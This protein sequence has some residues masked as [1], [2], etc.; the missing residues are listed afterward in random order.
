MCQIESLMVASWVDYVRLTWGVVASSNN[1][2]ED[3]DDLAMRVNL[4]AIEAARSAAYEEPGQ[5]QRSLVLGYMGKHAGGCFIGQSHNGGMMQA[6]GIAADNLRSQACYWDNCSRV[7][8]QVTSWQDDDPEYVLERIYSYLTSPS[9]QA[10]VGRRKI[11][12]IQ[13]HNGGTTIYVGSRTSEL[14]YRIYNKEAQSGEAEYDGAVRFEV[15]LKS[16][17]A[18]AAWGV[19]ERTTSGD[20][21]GDYVTSLYGRIGITLKGGYQRNTKVLQKKRMP[22]DVSSKIDWLKKQVGPSIEKLIAM[23]VDRRVILDA[24]RLWEV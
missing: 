1:P 8:V 18:K 6:A 13:N 20:V 11:T 9:G 22:Q 7:D 15:E 14:F 23:G 19:I 3:V 16:H 4:A 10:A 12:R 21:V 24:L 2:D 5:W 17:A